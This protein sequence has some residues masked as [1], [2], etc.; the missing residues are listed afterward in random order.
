MIERLAAF[1]AAG[2]G[3]SSWGP[4]VYGLV[5]HP[6]AARDLAQ[7]V[8]AYLGGRGAVIETA[9]ADRGARIDSVWAPPEGGETGGPAEG[10][11]G[12]N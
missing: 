3:Q 9:F 10:V 4:T 5:P 6:D 11:A 1:G 2:V 12:R 8:R 7:R